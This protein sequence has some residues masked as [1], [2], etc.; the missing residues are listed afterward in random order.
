MLYQN[1]YTEVSESEEN[2][3]NTIIIGANLCTPGGI[4]MHKNYNNIVILI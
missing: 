4:V 1:Y 3:Y 2:N